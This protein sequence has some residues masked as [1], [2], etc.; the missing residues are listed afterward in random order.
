MLVI[1]TVFPTITKSPGFAEECSSML[2]P[3]VSVVGWAEADR[4][5]HS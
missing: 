1:K 2:V 3:K 5:A 4:K